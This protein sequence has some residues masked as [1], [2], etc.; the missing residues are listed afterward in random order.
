VTFAVVRSRPAA[1]SLATVTE[2]HYGWKLGAPVPAGR[3]NR[4]PRIEAN[5]H[6]LSDIIAA[7]LGGRAA[8]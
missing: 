1:F 8:R 2:R 3:G 5:R 7:A 6:N 4:R